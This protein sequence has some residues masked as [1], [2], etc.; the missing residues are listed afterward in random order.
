MDAR[1]EREEAALDGR[2]LR[3]AD[4]ADLTALRERAGEHTGEIRRLLE[5]EHDRRHV[6]AH[7][8]AARGDEYRLREIGADAVGRIL[9]LEAVAD[10]EI[11]A[12]RAILPEVLLEVRRGSHFDVAHLR[13]ETVAHAEQTLVGAGVPA[14]IGDRAWSKERDSEGPLAVLVPVGLTPASERD[15]AH[16]DVHRC[17]DAAERGD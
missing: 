8:I 4:R 11:V 7:A 15:D 2:E 13:A 9:E 17:G 5:P 10:H 14:V 1:L 12:L 3:A 6:R 16:R